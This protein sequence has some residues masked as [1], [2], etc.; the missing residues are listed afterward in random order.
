[1]IEFLEVATLDYMVVEKACRDLGKKL[2]EAEG[3]PYCGIELGMFQ[4]GKDS[5][6]GHRK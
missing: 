3:R 2:P 1:M 5:M 6:C 4:N